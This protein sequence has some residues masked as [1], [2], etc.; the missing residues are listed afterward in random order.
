MN[1]SSLFFA[2]SYSKYYQYF[3]R[4]DFFFVVDTCNVWH[5]KPRSIAVC[6]FFIV[7]IQDYWKYYYR[8]IVS[9]TRG[10][11]THALSVLCHLCMCLFLFPL[12]LS[13]IEMRTVPC[14]LCFFSLFVFFL[15]RILHIIFFVC[16][17][18]VVP[19]GLNSLI[20]SE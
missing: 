10:L 1:L 15:F 8:Y 17:H 18:E 4:L 20:Q 11:Q 14:S 7:C 3:I 6:H 12:Y 2:R 5:F 13:Q 9:H 19:I 16:V